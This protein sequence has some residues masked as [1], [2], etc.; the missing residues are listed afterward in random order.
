M[1]GSLKLVFLPSLCLCVSVV[2]SS[3]GQE[4]WATYRG[5]SQRTGCADGKAGPTK[6]DVLWVHKSADHYI[7]APV[8]LGQRLF[9][10]GISGFNVPGIQMLDV[11]PQA[12]QRAV[13][14]KS[15]PVLKFPTVSS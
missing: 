14:T 12:K 15:A 8:P 1:N 7:A 5:N 13:W 4:A 3:S 9:V 10:S 6:P 2:N 11:N